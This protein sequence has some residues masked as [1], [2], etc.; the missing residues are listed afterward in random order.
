MME[1]AIFIA[2]VTSPLVS[3]GYGSSSNRKRERE[4][5]R[6]EKMRLSEDEAIA[7]QAEGRCTPCKRSLTT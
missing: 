1:Y 5:K 6:F 7:A 2:M 3:R 4:K